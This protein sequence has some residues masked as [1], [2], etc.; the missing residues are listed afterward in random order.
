MIRSTAALRLFRVLVS[1]AHSCAL[2]AIPVY[3]GPTT[4]RLTNCVASIPLPESGLVVEVADSIVAPGGL[5]LFVRRE[6]GAA[7]V[8]ID[9]LSPFCGYAHGTM[10]EVADSAGGKTVAFSLQSL[11]TTVFFEGAMWSVGELLERELRI[12][13]YTATRDAQTGALA[14][15]AVDETYRGPRY[16]VP[17]S[18]PGELTIMNCGQMA[19]DL[20]IG[21][22]NGGAAYADASRTVNLLALVQR[23]ERDPTHED[24]TVLRA[25]R[26]V[27]TLARTVCIANEK[28]AEVGCEYGAGYWGVG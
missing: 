11:S 18:P 20:A 9:A 2:T 21:D 13:G 6:A 24:G 12:A 28:P 8:T 23:L 22:G 17:A 1:L 26:P 3:G 25:S 5:G 7:P 10:R 4:E 15:L 27:S 14:G 19:N 16:F